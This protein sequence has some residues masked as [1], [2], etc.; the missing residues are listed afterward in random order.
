MHVPVR[1]DN[2]VGR[3]IHMVNVEPFHKNLGEMV[4]AAERC[5]QLRQ[6]LPALVLIYS[7][8]DSLAWAAAGDTQSV[9]RKRFESWVSS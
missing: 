4:L 1:L 5:I 9:V 6:H 7:L 3:V 2:N 8:V